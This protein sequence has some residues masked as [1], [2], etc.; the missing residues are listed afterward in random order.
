RSRRRPDHYIITLLLTTIILTQQTD[1][2]VLGMISK[3]GFPSGI[4]DAC[5]CSDWKQAPSL[6]VE[7][8]QY[9]PRSCRRQSI[10]QQ[11]SSDKLF[12]GQSG[13]KKRDGINTDAAVKR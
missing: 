3:A 4:C 2:Q 13:C 9:S 12:D 6:C 11:E 1:S 8:E 10:H 7:I 5:V